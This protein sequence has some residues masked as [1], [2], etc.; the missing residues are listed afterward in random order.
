MREFLSDKDD[1]NRNFIQPELV[2][3]VMQRE[4]EISL[5]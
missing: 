1:V 4:L 3:E 5:Q 2:K